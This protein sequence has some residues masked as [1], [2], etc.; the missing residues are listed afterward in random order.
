MTA[1]DTSST[2]VKKSAGWI[3]DQMNTATYT[4]N[5]V[6]VIHDSHKKQQIRDRPQ[7]RLP[8]A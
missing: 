6:L 7:S 1:G 8:E 4:I 2:Q 5:Q 3:S